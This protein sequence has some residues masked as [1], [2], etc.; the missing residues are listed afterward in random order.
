MMT[1]SNMKFSSTS[2]WYDQQ[3]AAE[4]FGMKWAGVCKYLFPISQLSLSLSLFTIYYYNW[5]I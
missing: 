2:G 4:I 1:L 3:D 5:E